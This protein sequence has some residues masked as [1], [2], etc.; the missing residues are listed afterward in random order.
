MRE[1]KQMRDSQDV[2]ARNIDGA[3]THANLTAKDAISGAD[4]AKNDA[5]MSRGPGDSSHQNA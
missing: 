5:L 2:R 3:I 4:E 1:D